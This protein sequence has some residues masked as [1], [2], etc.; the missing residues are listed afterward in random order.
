LPRHDGNGADR[1]LRRTVD[2]LAAGGDVDERVPGFID[3]AVATR[4]LEA[5]AGLPAERLFIV[6][7]FRQVDERLDSNARSAYPVSSAA[8]DLSPAD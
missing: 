2:D 4:R 3:H 1:F 6:A 7:Q 8:I 5:D